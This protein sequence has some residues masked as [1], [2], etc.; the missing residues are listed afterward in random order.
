MFYELEFGKRRYSD[1]K[2][3]I[4]PFLPLSNMS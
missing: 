3:Y 4:L 1:L 2:M